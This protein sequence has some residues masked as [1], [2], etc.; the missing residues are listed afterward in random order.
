MACFQSHLRDHERITLQ[1]SYDLRISLVMLILPA[2][3]DC[4]IMGMRYSA[5]GDPY[6]RNS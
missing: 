5:L 2:Q 1:V 4:V 3:G 6:R